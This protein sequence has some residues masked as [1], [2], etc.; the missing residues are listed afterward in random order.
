LLSWD[1][2][3]GAKILWKSAVP[4]PGHSSPVVWSNRV[5]VTGGNAEMREVLAYDS[6][7]GQLLWRCAVENIPGSPRPLPEVPED[8]GFAASTPA[9]DGHLL[10]AIF[11][12][13]DLVAVN[14]N[15]GIAWTKALGPIKN[16]YGFAT[17]LALWQGRLL[18]QLDQGEG[19]EA[20]SKL[21]A[22]DAA[23]GRVVW[24]RSRPVPVSW[25][26]PIVIEADGKKQIITLGNPWAI[27]YSFADGSELW[28]ADCLENEIVPSPVFAGGLVV[29]ASPS[30]RLVAIRPD[31]A[32]DVT[33]THLAWTFEDNVPDIASPVANDEFVFIVTSGGLLSCLDL[34]TG[35]KIWEH[36]FDLQV[37]SSPA[38]AGDRLLI[39]G[40]RGEAL[41][42]TAAPEFKEFARVQ[43]PDRFRASPALANGRV[44]LRGAT[45][46]FCLGPA[47]VAAAKGP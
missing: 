15:G 31:G 4:A 32:G 3:S 23:T 10:F 40:N 30:S 7:N 44:F 16:T 11:G 19:R 33:K 17:S 39:V 28:R 21:L 14:F 26:T 12:N 34:K 25:A 18:V 6:A 9:T 38:L 45:N 22:F 24:E 47:N 41:V 36:N 1:A 42:V 43:L 13:G 20:G 2:Q 46:L 37:E 8:T 27:A 35:N 29:L 5:F